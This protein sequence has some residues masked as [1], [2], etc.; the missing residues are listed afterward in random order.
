MPLAP[1]YEDGFIRWRVEVRTRL[2]GPDY[3]TRFPLAE[4]DEEEE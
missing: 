4:P 1:L 3:R 2:L